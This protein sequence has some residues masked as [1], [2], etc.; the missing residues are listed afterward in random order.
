LWA[1]VHGGKRK[2]DSSTRRNA[3]STGQRLDETVGSGWKPAPAW[4]L[5][6][7]G[8]PAVKT[9]RLDPVEGLRYE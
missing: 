3:D 4:G 2:L 9:T 5:P 1:G 6:A 7:A 8:R